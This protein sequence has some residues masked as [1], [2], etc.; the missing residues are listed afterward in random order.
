MTVP[1]FT[2][3]GR[4]QARIRL[5]CAICGEQ[6]AQAEYGRP[7]LLCANPECTKKRR[8]WRT[9]LWA[10][11]DFD[12]AVK[13]WQDA[14][15]FCGD[16]GPLFPSA[17]HLPPVPACHQCYHDAGQQLRASPEA[18]KRLAY[19]VSNA[20]RGAPLPRPFFGLPK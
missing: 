3:R 17:H 5:H 4:R 7:R 9:H 18:V 6:M 16:A 1:T 2:L 12:E 11:E 20:H 8:L 15:A 13:N 19:Y 10:R 14:C